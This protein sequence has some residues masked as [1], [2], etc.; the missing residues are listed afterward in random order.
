MILKEAR[1]GLGKH[2]ETV[3]LSGAIFYV[4]TL[5]FNGLL[6]NVCLPLVKVSVLCFYRRIFSITK[7]TRQVLWITTGVTVAW[8]ISM[9]TACLLECV[10]VNAIWTPTIKGKCIDVLKFYYGSAGSSIVLDFALL[11]IP[12]P[13]VWRLHM[14][15]SHKVALSTTFL[16]GYLN[17]VISFV[18][19]AYLIKV[20][21]KIKDPD[22]TWN[23]F[24]L[25]AW[26]IAE[27][28]VALISA[29]IPSLQFLFTRFVKNIKRRSTRS[30]SHGT[31]AGRHD[32]HSII[33]RGVARQDGGFQRLEDERSALG[34]NRIHDQYGVSAYSQDYSASD[35]EFELERSNIIVP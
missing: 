10:P 28:S 18:R 20:G 6:Y 2:V 29:H 30:S 31:R 8:C 16:L 35:N 5:Y 11:V 9:V 12:V 26:S 7:R 15:W 1:H 32:T 13:L 3:G 33:K 27:V 21:P 24:D 22:V 23:Y 4:H 14:D 25:S 19:L 17:P 34:L